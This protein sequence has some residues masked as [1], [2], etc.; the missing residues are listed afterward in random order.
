[1]GRGDVALPTPGRRIQS[2]GD[3][4][5]DAS[6]PAGY[7]RKRQGDVIDAIGALN[8]SSIREGL[9]WAGQ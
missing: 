4:V 6:N 9:V 2:A 7:D 3:P 5:H 1:M 8:R